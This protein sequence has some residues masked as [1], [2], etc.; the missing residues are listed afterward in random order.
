MFE[1]IIERWVISINI[2]WIL[3]NKEL[4]V[5]N[6]E[7]HIINVNCGFTYLASI[8]LFFVMWE[9][10][11]I[12]YLNVNDH[13]I[14]CMKLFPKLVE[15]VAAQKIMI[16]NAP[17]FMDQHARRVQKFVCALLTAQNDN[18]LL[19]GSRTRDFVTGALGRNRARIESRQQ[20]TLP[21]EIYVCH[22]AT[23]K[24]PDQLADAERVRELFDARDGV[25]ELNGIHLR[26]YVSWLS[27]YVVYDIPL[28][29]HW[30]KWEWPGI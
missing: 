16:L 7:K 17:S 21:H 18:V 22:S 4:G 24:P 30:G 28:C 2:V 6:Q 26:T 8:V 29:L 1:L 9:K 5:R 14:L 23:R 15:D 13:S 19:I 11:A 3:R 10:K 12:A 20:I 27:I 25:V